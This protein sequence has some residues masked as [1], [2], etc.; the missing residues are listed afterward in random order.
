MW[1]YCYL[2]LILNDLF[3]FV[4]P[5]FFIWILSSIQIFII[6]FFSEIICKLRDI[7]RLRSHTSIKSRRS[8]YVFKLNK[9][10]SQCLN[11]N[12]LILLQMLYF[13]LFVAI[14]NWYFANLRPNL[15]FMFKYAL[16]TRTTP[17]ITALITFRLT[18]PHT[19][20]ITSRRLL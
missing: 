12:L 5:N 9:I 11:F 17:L 6:G 2:S 14:Y 7:V 19:I 15:S 10:A 18:I 3:V 1:I 16:V 13:T 8:Y 20:S 4:F